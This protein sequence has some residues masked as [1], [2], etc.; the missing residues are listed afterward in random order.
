[1][2]FKHGLIK[3]NLRLVILSYL[4]I[5]Q[6]NTTWCLQGRKSMINATHHMIQKYITQDTIKS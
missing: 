3:R 2:A 6:R 5:A 1:M 4:I